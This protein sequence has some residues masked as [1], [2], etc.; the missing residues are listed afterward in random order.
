MTDDAQGTIARLQQLRDATD[1]ILKR[2]ADE[3]HRICDKEAVNWADLRCPE[4]RHILDSDRMEYDQVLI[5]EVSPSSY[6]L[7]KAVQERLAKEGYPNVYV[8]TEW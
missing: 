1:R 2:D 8:I 6:F 7:A 3:L 5:E 4:A